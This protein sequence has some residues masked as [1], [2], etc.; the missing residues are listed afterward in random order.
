MLVHFK[1]YNVTTIFEICVLWWSFNIFVQLFSP[2]FHFNISHFFQV[3]R[4]YFM[5]NGRM[6]MFASKYMRKGKQNTKTKSS[7]Y[8][9]GSEPAWTNC[10]TD[11]NWISLLFLHCVISYLAFFIWMIMCLVWAYFDLYYAYMTSSM[12]VLV[13]AEIHCFL[14]IALRPA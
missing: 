8:N 9:S 10:S 14:N 1:S 2:L 3:K 13:T 7:L 4:K 6:F 5:A 12:T 11:L